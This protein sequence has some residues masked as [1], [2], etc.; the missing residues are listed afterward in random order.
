MVASIP[1]TPATT[2]NIS[3]IF[4]DFRGLLTLTR[5]RVTGN[6]TE[7]TLA[8]YSGLLINPLSK[9]LSVSS[10]SPSAIQPPQCF[11]LCSHGQQPTTNLAL[12]NVS[13]HNHVDWFL[14]IGVNQYVTLDLVTLP[15]S[16]PYLSNDHLHVSDGKGL[17]ISNIGHTKMHFY[18]I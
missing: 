3:M 5:S 9:T 18:L 10:A 8:L 1:T 7:G 11:Q 4:L 15:E 13:T 2:T 14:N 6:K 17:S 12:G 16:A